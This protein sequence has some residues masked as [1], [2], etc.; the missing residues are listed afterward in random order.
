MDDTSPRQTLPQ[1]STGLSSGP[2]AAGQIGMVTVVA[3]FK[4]SW[5]PS[6]GEAKG[7]EPV[8]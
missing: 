4:L 5:A 6:G 7:P 1:T 2:P 8:A 3:G